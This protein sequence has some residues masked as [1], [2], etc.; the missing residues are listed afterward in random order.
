MCRLRQDRNPFWDRRIFFADKPALTVAILKSK[1]YINLDILLVVSISVCCGG[2][3]LKLKIHR[4]FF[5]LLLFIV[6]GFL[7]SAV[8][9]QNQ[10]NKAVPALTKVVFTPQWFPQ[11]QFAGYYMAQ[12]LGIY[13]KY[14]L[15]V[16]FQYKQP[17]RTLISVLTEKNA[18][19][20]TDFLAS[21]IKMRANGI[22]II[23][24]G[25]ISQ[26]SALVFVARKSS[27]I[28]KLEDI[29][30]KKVGIW[31]TDFQEVPKALLER[32][33]IKAEIIPVVSGIELFL[34]RGIDVIAVMWYNE[35]H[36]LLSSGINEDEITTFFFNDYNLDIPEDGIYCLR[37][38]YEKNPEMCRNFTKA[39]L[40]GWQEAFKN[41]KR[42]LE[43]IRKYCR[44]NHIPYN[45]AHQS[46]MLNRME[47]LIFPS[48]GKHV[49]GF[50]APK[51]YLDT[52][53]KLKST[54]VIKT[55][56]PYG[57]FY[58]NVL[59][60]N[61]SSGRDESISGKEENVQK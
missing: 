48:G 31:M 43:I 33:K 10:D 53:K 45:N 42:T 14:G 30:G 41:K 59:N 5:A 26:R 36:E 2:I 51:M 32:H 7:S 19:F 37:E 15:D 3:V 27:G 57:E 20:V 39:S 1:N 52:A 17:Q 8:F 29:N 54:G 24:I 11:A 61:T 16:V 22:K 44:E 28:K 9:P 38:T 49:A 13:N 35:Y 56:P 58:K 50:L 23:N 12:E 18:D 21:G 55:I 40:E 25:Q 4:T 60:G 34:C 47:E 46:W 6:S